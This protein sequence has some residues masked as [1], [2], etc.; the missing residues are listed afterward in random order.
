MKKITGIKNVAE[1][2]ADELVDRLV[3][4]HFC[5]EPFKECET[6]IPGV[7]V[8]EGDMDVK[9]YR[10]KYWHWGCIYDHEKIGR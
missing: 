7:G 5:N 9:K 4:C 8:I 3:C 6:V 1:N 10:G 2:R